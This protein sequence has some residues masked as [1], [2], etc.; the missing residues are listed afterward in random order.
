MVS[1]EYLAGFVDGEGCLSVVGSSV[2]VR[3]TNTNKDLLEEIAGQWG[4]SVAVHHDGDEK[5]RRCYIWRVFG[6]QAAEVL[7]CTLPHLR[8]KRVQ[9]LLLQ[10]YRKVGPHAPLRAWI[11]AAL[12]ELKRLEFGTDASR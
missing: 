11:D 3:V 1:P 9:A 5:R 7:R 4:G 2:A 12:G 10:E 6:V 8:D